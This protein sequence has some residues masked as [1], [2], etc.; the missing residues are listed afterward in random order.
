MYKIGIDL[1]GTNI[2]IGII[3]GKYEIISFSTSKTEDRY[4]PDAV[5]EQIYNNAD[6]L[7]KKN[8]LSLSD[9]AGVGLGCPGI[10]DPESGTVIYSNNFNWLNFSVKE[11]LTNL[12]GLPVQIENDANC[13]V[14]GEAAAGGAKGCKNIVLLT[15]G[16]GVGSGIIVDGKL[17][18]GSGFGGVAGHM[19]VEL[20]G[21][22]CSCGKLGCLEAYTSATAL[23]S[24]TV[25]Q[26]E[27]HPDSLLAKLC[28]ND[29]QKV[30]GKLAF[31]A[32]KNG[33]PYAEK[34]IEEYIDALAHG[35]A[36]LINLFRPEK[37]LISGGVCNEGAALI[38]PLNR[39]IQKYC[40]AGKYITAPAVEICRLKNTAG[41]IGAASL[42]KIEGEKN[43]I[44]SRI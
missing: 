37:V 13:A 19:T 8:G 26:I 12:F 36:S 41:V 27:M 14:L 24:E 31:V 20:G 25:K 2:K 10:I 32:A 6:R 35:T 28:K 38:I 30:D 29:P 9:I 7:L 43:E 44:Q 5:I 33:D 18:S 34:V 39:K 15:L 42:I 17:L 23:I 22:P 1:G 3:D 40:F 11:K 21:R 16:T 4:N